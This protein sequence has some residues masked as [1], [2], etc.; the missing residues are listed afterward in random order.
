MCNFTGTNYHVLSV[1]EIDKK[2]RDAA[3]EVARKKNGTVRA[4]VLVMWEQ[5]VGK[6]VPTD[7]YPLPHP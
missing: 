1:P 3:R 2:I 4:K 6:D 7:N 5:G